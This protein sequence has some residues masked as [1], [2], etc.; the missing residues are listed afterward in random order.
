MG[1]SVK[2]LSALV[3]GGLILLVL[4]DAFETIILPRRVTRRIRLT[5]LFYRYTWLMCAYLVSSWASSRRR[6]AVYSFYGPLSLLTLVGL[7]ALG[8]MLGFACL[9]WAGGSALNSPDSQPSFLT[10]LY[11]SGTTF[12]TLGLGD[13]VPRTPVARVSCGPRGRDWIR[14]SCAYHRV[15]AAAQSGLLPSRSQHFPAGRPRR[16]ASDRCGNADPTSGLLRNGGAA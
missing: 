7:W 10:D 5:R 6:D 4:W 14:F 3:G 8:L 1:V 12:F 11:L 2:I 13:V 16:L 9:H 15:L